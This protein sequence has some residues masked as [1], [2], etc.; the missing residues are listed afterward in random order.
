M[1]S[2]TL[3]RSTLSKESMDVIEALSKEKTDNSI[4]DE[5]IRPEETV[6]EEQVNK[7]QEI[8]MLWQSFKSAQFSSNSP[9]MYV[10]TGFIIGV[11]TSVICFGFYHYYSKVHKAPK[12]PVNIE[13]IINDA[14]EAQIEKTEPEPVQEQEAAQADNVQDTN[15]EHAVQ[16]VTEP[17]KT[18]KYKVKNGDTGESIIKKFY[19]SYSP[20]KAD[21]IIKLNNLK[22]LDRINIDQ[23]LLIPVE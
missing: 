19:G 4:I 20:E 9:A 10:L 5:Y 7:A 15:S 17:V 12:M 23:E 16:A 3:R 1:K 14:P 11:L 21:K 2:S 13:S 22:N 18:Q 6:P 8:D